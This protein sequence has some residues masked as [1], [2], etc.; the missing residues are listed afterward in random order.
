MTIS[1]KA[2][3]GHP[4]KNWFSLKKILFHRVRRRLS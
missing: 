3:K 1:D 4:E 2:E